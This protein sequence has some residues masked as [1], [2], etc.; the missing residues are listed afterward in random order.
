MP[1]T[2]DCE[3]TK[4]L[5][6]H[7]ASIRCQANSYTV[8]DAE[9]QAGL[10]N[11]T[12]RF[13]YLKSICTRTDADE[14][15]GKFYNEGSHL[16]QPASGKMPHRIG[17]KLVAQLE[18]LVWEKLVDQYFKEYLGTVLDDIGA[19]E[20]FINP[21]SADSPDVMTVLQDYMTG[22]DG[23]DDGQIKVIKADA[24]V[25]KT[26]VSRTLVQRLAHRTRNT[27]TIPIYVEA[28]HWKRHLHDD[29]SLYDVIR[30]SL[31][32]LNAQ[33]IP[34][35]VF[36][37]ALRR[38][39]LSFIFDGFDELCSY[40]TTSFN[41]T[42]VLNEL[43]SYSESKE[44]EARILLTT[45]SG[46]WTARVENTTDISVIL[47][48]PFNTQ[49]A[50]GYF[51]N[52]FGQGTR[53]LQEVVGLHKRLRENTVPIE[54]SGSVRD[55]LFNLPFCVRVLADY[56]KDGGR[57]DGL[58]DMTFDG[59]MLAICQRERARQHLET[60]AEEQIRS[61]IDVALA[62]DTE[63]PRFALDDLLSL[64]GG[65]IHVDDR[66]RIREH[67]LIE[68]LPI[69]SLDLQQDD[70]EFRFRYEFLAP[71]L[72]ALG[73][74]DVLAN[75]EQD[76]QGGITKVLERERDGEGEVSENLRRILRPADWKA[77]ALR[78][79]A[80]VADR[81]FAL[82][83]FF[84]HLGLRVS[85]LDITV[86]SDTKR[87]RVLFGVVTEE[88]PELLGWSF[89]GTIDGLDL[90]GMKFKSCRFR[91]VKFRNCNVDSKTVF[92]DCTFEG[93][94]NLGGQKQWATVDYRNNCVATFPADSTWESVLKR[95]VGERAE[96]IEVLLDIALSK[97]WHGGRLQASVAKT[98]WRRGW[99]GESRAA[100]RVSNS[101]LKFG[102][103]SEI[104]I[105][106]VAGG[107]YGFDR[108]SLPDLQNFMDSRQK[109]GK[110]KLVFDDLMEY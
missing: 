110:V 34:E 82:A 13:I 83:S 107:G 101:M 87:T 49:Q 48:K 26:T 63:R 78:C 9:A 6:Y 30:N 89:Y 32:Q 52:V 38:G 2:F 84:F 55:E 71:Y 20:N 96:R 74:R 31:A 67:A 16:L 54:H 51:R 43:R 46:F 60:S 86:A 59:L 3:D 37:H 81:Y 90:G 77:A 24:G 62:D 12:T 61:F 99:R 25:G 39:Y 47:L 76:L 19:D 75:P 8:I 40:H 53:E 15:I 11:V 28:Q 85:K 106:G 69:H 42:D 35:Q 98:N 5:G 70:N 91:D 23:K 103:I 58:E 33:L 64:P 94:I 95:S 57:P 44:S 80:A 14:A 27:K 97:F 100:R 45:R 7:H 50:R 4:L 108:D 109:S 66:T 29:S 79:R 72:R 105:S 68:R 65:G 1:K 18:D 102:L 36:R 41:P 93:N 22:K 10:G 56:V 21:T 73:V 104:H 92:D 17:G 88:Y